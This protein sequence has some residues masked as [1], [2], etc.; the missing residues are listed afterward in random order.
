MALPVSLCLFASTPDITDLGFI[1]RVLTGNID[2]LPKQAIE[3]GYDG[4]EF[5]PDPEKVPEPAV[6]ERALKAAG[7]A[8]P[9]VNTG[10][11]GVQRMAL[12]DDDEAVRS[13]SIA[14]FKR[15]LDFAGFFG[16][17]VGLG[18]ARGKGIP[19]ATREHMDRLAGD[20]F[21]ELAEHAERTGAVIM[22]EP[23]D[24]GVT[25]YINTVDEAMEWVRR[26]ASPAF[27]VMLDT[28]ELA[29]S[30]PSIEHGI[31]AARGQAHHIHLYDPSRW[32][33]GVR[34]ETNRLDWPVVFK[35]LR[36][37]SFR[38]SASVVLVPEGD[39][40]PAARQTASFIRRAF[41]G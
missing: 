13:R 34:A 39:P 7:A 30:E 15:M 5:M 27:S 28:Y 6:M 38:G 4:I 25:S 32:P 33:P 41:T 24:P 2:E 3:W 16:A 9:V 35:L 23:A 36:E 19:G 29:E 26:I 20:V 12:I 8:M 40:A 18:I 22:L 1:V 31:R 11:M 21:R 37:T 14:A 17:R 10:R